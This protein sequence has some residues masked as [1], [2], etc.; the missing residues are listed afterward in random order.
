MKNDVILEASNN[1]LKNLSI[2]LNVK[3]QFVR[4]HDLCER[5]LLGASGYPTLPYP[6]KAETEYLQPA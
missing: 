1:I 2:G 5:I 3:L 6:P 4:I